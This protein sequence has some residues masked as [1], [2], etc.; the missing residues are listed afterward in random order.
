MNILDSGLD[1][2]LHTLTPVVHQVAKEMEEFAKSHQFPIVGPLVG[3][4]L[5]QYA[6]ISGAQRVLE[7]GSGFGYSAFWWGVGTVPEG[8]IICTEGSAENVNRAELY[9]GRAG[10]WHK[11]E[12]LIGDALET[13]E[14]L[15]GEFDII[16]MD[17]DKDQYPEGFRKSFPRLREGGMFIADNVL[18]SGRVL[19][20]DPDSSTKGIQ[21]FNRLIYST[22]GAFSTILPIRDGLSV[23]LKHQP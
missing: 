23:T 9:L 11:T 7:L 3:R 5:C 13:M 17:I 10:L 14:R 8:R 6:L 2:Y 20:E 4:I 12:Y 15:E 19:D 22:P 18:W 21:E 16:F 1:S